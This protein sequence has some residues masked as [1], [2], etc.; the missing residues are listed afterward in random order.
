VLIAGALLLVGAAFRGQMLGLAM[1]L[2][3][4]IAMFAYRFDVPMLYQST[5]VAAMVA[6]GVWLFAVIFLRVRHE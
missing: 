4:W 1:Y 2:S 6:L 5:F 3:A